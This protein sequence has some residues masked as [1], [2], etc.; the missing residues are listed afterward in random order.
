M[1]RPKRYVIRSAR[2]DE[3]STVDRPAQQGAVA[4]IMKSATRP[5]GTA[6]RKN[7][8]DVWDSGS[9]PAFSVA[10]YEDEIMKRA[11]EIAEARN[12]TNESALAKYLPTD[13]TLR[14]LAGAMEEARVNAYRLHKAAKYGGA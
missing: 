5:A 3:I 9:K 7:A 1:Q 2:L 11:G 8:A 12:L 14:Q 4:V 13:T 10:D 6:I